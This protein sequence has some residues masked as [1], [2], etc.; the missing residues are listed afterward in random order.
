[1]S[2]YSLYRS[3]LRDMTVWGNALLCCPIRFYETRDRVHRFAFEY[4]NRLRREPL[5]ILMER[6][7]AR[8]SSPRR[9]EDVDPLWSVST[10]SSQTSVTSSPVVASAAGKELRK[11]RICA[12]SRLHWIAGV[13]AVASLLHLFLFVNLYPRPSFSP[14][15][16]KA[17]PSGNLTTFSPKELECGVFLSDDCE[18]VNEEESPQLLNPKKRI[19]QHIHQTYKTDQIPDKMVPLVR[20]WRHM[21]PTWHYSFYNDSQCLQFVEQEFP[22]YLEAYNALPK[23]VERSDFFRYMVILRYGGVYADLDTECLI[24][25]DDIIDAEDEMIVGWEGDLKD[26]TAAIPRHFVRRR[27]VLQWIFAAVAGHPALKEIC[28]LI[29]SKAKE[30]QPVTNSNYE[31][32]EKTGP[33]VFTD[34]IMKYVTPPDEPHNIRIMP[35]AA[36]GSH[37]SGEDGILPDSPAILIKHHFFGSWK[38]GNWGYPK[39]LQILQSFLKLEHFSWIQVV[40]PISL[41]FFPVRASF[42]PTFTVVVHGAERGAYVADSDVSAEISRWGVWQAGS[43]LPPRPR[44]VDVLAGSLG[45]SNMHLG[46]LDIGAGLGFFSLAAASRHHPVVALEL[47][48]SNIKP[49]NMSIH[50]NGFAEVLKLHTNINDF[51]NASRSLCTKPKSETNDRMNDEEHSVSEE[52]MQNANVTDC[53]MQVAALRL[54]YTGWSVWKEINGSDYVRRFHP[55]IVAIEY[56]PWQMKHHGWQNPLKFLQSMTEEMGYTEVYHA[57]QLCKRRWQTLVDHVH[58]FKKHE[59]P[60]WCNVDTSDFEIFLR[61]EDNELQAPENVLFVDS[62]RKKT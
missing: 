36:F 20:S 34:I 18:D 16:N 28:D 35:Q 27:Q 62:R 19:P 48:D 32:L 53:A 4:D 42:T 1:M 50:T 24:S 17:V 44:L 10:H 14:E 9:A 52:E 60:S 13:V 39:E 33:G 29:V 26:E 59:A 47:T 41:T 30:S 25:M 40:K 57:G 7:P 56:S 23:S 8:S 46:F 11:R 43:L 31:T 51:K 54:G 21:N 45:D 49:F 3:C 37:P 15:N 2:E 6:L 5:T 12:Q 58:D 22:E 61:I 55:D 38:T